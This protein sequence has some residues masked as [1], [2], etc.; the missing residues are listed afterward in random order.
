MGVDSGSLQV[1]ERDGAV[2]FSVR[3]KP[4]ASRN[5]VL[6]VRE[7][8]LELSVTAPPVDGQA[9][10]AIVKALAAVFDVP[11]RDVRI[12]AGETGRQKIVEVCGLGEATLRAR[13]EAA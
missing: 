7:G 13:L 5:S 6:G 8:A 2:R 4:R 9:N 3:V 12:V 10:E 1:T 11:R